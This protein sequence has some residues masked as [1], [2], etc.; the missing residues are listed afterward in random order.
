MKVLVGE[1]KIKGERGLFASTNI[2]RGEYVCALPIDYLKI[3]SKWYS[4]NPKDTGPINFRYGIQC[5][6]VVPQSDKNVSVLGTFV[7]FL[8]SPRII[9]RSSLR[10]GL[11]GVSNPNRLE[12]DFLGHMMNDY[13]DMSLLDKHRYEQLSL[14]HENVEVDGD[15]EI[16]NSPTGLRLGLR[17]VAKRNIRRGEE[18]FFSYGVDYWKNYSGPEKIEINP[19]IEYIQLRT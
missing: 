12:H 1:S 7:N 3:S 5:D 16:F 13:V 4:L 9:T 8:T 6:L 18:L 2:K 11:S 17:V 10:I 15:L 14:P 19:P